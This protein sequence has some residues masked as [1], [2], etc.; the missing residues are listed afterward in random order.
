MDAGQRR[1]R[2]AG[3]HQAD[4]VA[5]SRAAS[6]RNGGR[7]GGRARASGHRRRAG[8]RRRAKSRPS[9]SVSETTPQGALHQHLIRGSPPS[10]S[11]STSSVEPPPMS[12]ISAGPSPGSSSRWQPSMASRASSSGAMIS[13]AMPV[14]RRTRSTKSRPL[15]A[16]RQASVATERA[17][18]D[19]AAP[20]LL[21]ADRE[22]GDRAVHRPFGELARWSPCPRPAGRR[23]RRRR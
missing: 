8:P 19:A 22:R 4:V 15:T 6:R 12:K 1:H 21:G 7:R 16:R 17:R 20:Q 14:S 5:C 2:A 11:T 23:A 9:L 10:V 13:S 18:R 3:A